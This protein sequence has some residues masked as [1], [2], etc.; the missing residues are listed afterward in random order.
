MNRLVCTLLAVPLLA[1]VAYADCVTGN[2]VSGQGKWR[3]ED[4]SQYQGT[5]R[6]GKREGPGVLTRATGSVLSGQWVQDVTRGPAVYRFTNRA[7]YVAEWRGDSP[8]TDLVAEPWAYSSGGIY[9]GDHNG[10]EHGLGGVQYADGATYLG[11][12]VQGKKQGQGMMTWPSGA[13]YF[14]QW[15]AGKPEGQGQ[16]VLPDQSVYSGAWH[17]GLPE[18]HGRLTK[19]DG[20]SREGQWRAGRWIGAATPPPPN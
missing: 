17:D 12:Y 2:C 19:P 5:W 11:D 16:F 8:A 1:Q 15:S 4:G 14:G 10:L 6:D 9:I 20:S 18:G 13:K 3:Y 7:R